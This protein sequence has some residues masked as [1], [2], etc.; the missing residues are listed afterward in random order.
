MYGQPGREDA[1]I[2]EVCLLPNCRREH[3][4]CS[5]RPTCKRCG[6]QLR[7]ADL[8]RLCGFCREEIG[9]AACPAPA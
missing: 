8:S 3:R 9:I 7:R 1:T 2:C 6:E 4:D 5:P